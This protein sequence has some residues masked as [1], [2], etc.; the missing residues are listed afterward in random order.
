MTVCHP[1]SGQESQWLHFL[2]YVC[3]SDSLP[4][5][6]HLALPLPLPSVSLSLTL[7]L[8]VSPPL[9]VSVLGGWRILGEVG[10]VGVYGGIRDQR[11]QIQGRGLSAGLSQEGQ[12]LGQV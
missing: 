1:F 12:G 10:V 3:P 7:C 11:K 4:V 5:C 8:S 2:P 9:R 6:L